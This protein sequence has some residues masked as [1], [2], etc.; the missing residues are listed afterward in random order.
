[1]PK[2]EEIIERYQ[3]YSDQELLDTYLNI[4]EYTDEGKEAL[5]LVLKS[6]GGIDIVKER[7][8]KQLEIDSEVERIREEIVQLLSQGRNPKQIK[9]NIAISNISETHLEDIIEKVSAEFELE[10][11]DKQIKPKTIIGSIIGGFIGGTIGGII[12][13][14]QMVH[15][16]HIFLILAIGLVMLSYAFVRLF[17]QQ[18]KKNKIVLVMTVVSVI[19]ALMLG[20]LIFDVFGYVGK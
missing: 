8:T 10:K 17:T 12:W 7:I 1:M 20:Q 18:S 4:D 2:I 3:K 6:R 16:N 5:K 9:E 19:Y 11:S 13:G 15:S 14:V